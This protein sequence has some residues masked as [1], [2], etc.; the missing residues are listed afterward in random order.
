MDTQMCI[1]Y[2]A[3]LAS[4]A[5]GLKCLSR[6]HNRHVDAYPEQMRRSLTALH[7]V[8]LIDRHG[9]SGLLVRITDTF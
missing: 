9:L 6:V 5:V 1:H 8:L 3:Q 4:K 2:Q 7:G